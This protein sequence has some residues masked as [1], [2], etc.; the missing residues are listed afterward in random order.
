MSDITPKIEENWKK[1]LIKEFSKEYF[2]ELKNF[3]IKEKKDHEICP[4][5]QDI[6]NAFNLTSFNNVKVVILGQD[7]YHGE[8]QAHG[9]AFSVPNH[10]KQPP[11]LK[12]IFKE[13]SQ[14]INIPIPRTGN[15]TYWAKQG[16]LLLNSILTVRLKVA[17]SH[18]KKGWEIF[19]DTVIHKL[20]KERT[21]IVFMLWGRYAQEKAKIID[22]NKHLI[23]T[24]PHP[25]PFSAYTGFFGCNHFSKTNDFLKENGKNEID[26]KII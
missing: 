5:D 17:G 13:L 15:L 11:S 8:A 20:S 1:V 16:V 26:W 14:D 24:A 21:G 10:I 23:L 22:N 19:T 6:F 25:S 3:L 2:F 9:L 4:K 18:Q 12:N 7:P